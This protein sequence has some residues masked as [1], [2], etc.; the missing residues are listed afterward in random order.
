M[1]LGQLSLQGQTIVQRHDDVSALQ[2][3]GFQSIIDRFAMSI[4]Q[5]SA[6]QPND[7]RPSHRVIVSEDPLHSM[8]LGFV[9]VIDSE[10]LVGNEHH[11][12]IRRGTGT[13]L[14]G[15]PCGEPDE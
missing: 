13:M 10:R 7:E 12:H 9:Q 15:L 14:H 2:H 5:G 6:V 3:G 11:H 4:D 1:I 8:L